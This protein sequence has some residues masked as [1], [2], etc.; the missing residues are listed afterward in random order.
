MRSVLLVTV[1]LAALAVDAKN[2]TP[3]T[4]ATVT[5]RIHRQGA[6]ETLAE[7]YQD[8]TQWQELLAH[9]ATGRPAWLMVAKQLRVASDAG[10]NQQLE[11]AVGEA[12][13]H[14]PANVLRIAPPVFDIETV[15]SGPDVDDA[16]YDSY[17]LSIRAIERR[18]SRV[19]AVTDDSL[20]ALRDTCIAT[21]EKSKLGIAKFYGR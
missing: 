9:I 13:E 18:T 8:E 16:R 17:S 19:R 12:L 2:T 20:R 6:H 7:I 15:C 11:L 4:S 3:L 14:H 1:F 5:Q 21:L 10:A